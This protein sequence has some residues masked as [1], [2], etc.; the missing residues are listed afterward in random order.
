M[1]RSRT[2]IAVLAVGVLVLVAL[3]A[4]LWSTGDTDA[5][6]EY[7]TYAELKKDKSVHA[8]TVPDFV[9]G[10][11]RDIVGS[12]NVEFNTQTLEFTFDAA[13]KASLVSTFRGAIGSEA[14]SIVQSMRRARWRRSFP[15]GSQA[16]VYVRSGHE[17]LEEYLAVDVKNGQAYYTA[18]PSKG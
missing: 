7:A 16:E 10:S 6:Y 18:K 11:A 5:H 3:G 12:Y 1:L 14:D 4:Y 15:G 2:F 17:Q 8:A 9:P 13:D